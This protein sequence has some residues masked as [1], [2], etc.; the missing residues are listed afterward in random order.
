MIDLHNYLP[1][2]AKPHHIFLDGK[3]NLLCSNSKLLLD[4]QWL[5]FV[6]HIPSKILQPNH[7]FSISSPT[8]IMFV[9]TE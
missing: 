2:V 7:I 5:R 6:R 4:A 9:K 3:R 1:K 8:A